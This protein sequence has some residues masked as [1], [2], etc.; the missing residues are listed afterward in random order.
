METKHTT[1]PWKIEK[2]EVWA[3][4][5][6]DG[7]RLATMNWLK[8]SFGGQGRRDADEV[9]ANAA[10]IAAAPELLDLVI[11]ALKE[12]MDLR[13]QYRDQWFVASA[14]DAIARAT[15]NREEG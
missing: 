11:H 12:Q 7:G 14:E 6:K 10:L 4:I 15:L 5:G 2:E 9:R 8:G 1:G 3:I 13:P